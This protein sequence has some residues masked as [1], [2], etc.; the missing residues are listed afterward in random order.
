MIEKARIN[1]DTL[2]FNNVEFRQGDI[3]SL[4][5]A[6]NRADV[7]ISN[8]VLNLVPD[9]QKAFAE[10][11]RV[12]KPGGHFSVSDIVLRGEL[13]DALRHDAEMY[14]G[15]VS[16]AIQEHDYLSMLA[17][18]GFMGIA[19]Q[20]A[21]VVDLPDDILGSY[22]TT[23]EIATMRAGGTGIVSVNVYGMKPADQVC[24]PSSG[25]C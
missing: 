1:A 25:C 20:R 14:A 2:G 11:H 12:L 9:K 7:V 16:G 24:S 22:L 10:M 19:V 18:V 4:P 23:E 13:P 6:A 3:E 17:D 15:C 8:C 21:T 5:I